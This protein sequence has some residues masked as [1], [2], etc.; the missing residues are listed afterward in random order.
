LPLLAF[1]QFQPGITASSNNAKEYRQRISPTNSAQR[2]T[3]S[4]L[5]ASRIA[6]ADNDPNAIVVM[7]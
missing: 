4:A 1:H 3:T 6:R 5:L 7:K 2:H